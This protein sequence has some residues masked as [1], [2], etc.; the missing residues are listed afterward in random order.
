MSERTYGIQHNKSPFVR[1]MTT[2]F[3][4]THSVLCS[5]IMDGDGQL[6]KPY[7]RE[8]RGPA[9]QIGKLDDRTSTHALK[10]K[11]GSRGLRHEYL[12][13]L[14]AR[15]GKA[16]PQRHTFER[17]LLPGE[18][19]TGGICS[20]PEC[21]R[22]ASQKGAGEGSKKKKPQ[23]QVIVLEFH[24]Y[25]HTGISGNRPSS[26]IATA[27]ELPAEEKAFRKVSVEYPHTSSCGCKL[28]PT[29]EQQPAPQVHLQSK[30]TL[31]YC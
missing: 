29:L 9:Q 21:A 16:R 23:P 30:P 27:V 22:Y 20:R 28:F 26:S 3:P 19:P 11:P 17:P 12:K 2:A 14:C 6:W 4:C 1:R 8:S 5:C 31:V 13:H 25:L 10:R 15:C 7:Y 18:D 24:H